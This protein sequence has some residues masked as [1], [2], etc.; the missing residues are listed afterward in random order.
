[1]DV[2]VV[3]VPVTTTHFDLTMQFQ[4]TG[5][6]LAGA[7]QYNT[8]LFD[9][10]TMHRMAGHLQMLLAGI[11]TDP[12]QPVWALPLLTDTEQ[13]QILVQCNDTD[14]EV[15]PATLPEL[16]TAQVSAHPDAEAVHCGPVSLSYTELDEQANRLAHWLIGLGVGPERLVAVALPRSVDLVVALLA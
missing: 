10:A 8:D 7:L 12:D 11:V 6:E 16:F 15:P 3:E 4:E 2:S 5:D 1:M 9:T 13:H 14:R